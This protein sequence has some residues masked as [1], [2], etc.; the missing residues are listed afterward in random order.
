MSHIPPLSGQEMVGLLGRL[1]FVPT[2]QHGSH[3]VLRQPQAPFR[4][5]TVPLHPELARGTMAAIAREA[6]LDLTRLAELA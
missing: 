2:R 5:L 1:G 4:R 6:G 3:L